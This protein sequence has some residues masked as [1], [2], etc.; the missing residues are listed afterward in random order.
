[1]V[2]LPSYPEYENYE[3]KK[4]LE[5]I[6]VR[7]F[8]LD[9]ISVDY[10][11]DMDI[12]R[13]GFVV[14]F[15]NNIDLLSITEILN[16]KFHLS[17]TGSELLYQLAENLCSLAIVSEMNQLDNI[18]DDH[19]KIKFALNALSINYFGTIIDND[20]NGFD[21]RINHQVLKFFEHLNSI[22]VETSN[23]LNAPTPQDF[24]NAFID[25][26]RIIKTE[27]EKLIPHL[28]GFEEKCLFSEF[29]ISKFLPETQRKYVTFRATSSQVLSSPRRNISEIS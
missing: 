14:K 12:H 3:I 15:E 13:N 17:E 24:K 26:E 19:R 7:I 9:I 20:G 2:I 10:F 5:I 11:K 28:I 1:M 29:N 8:P 18:F 22:C 23:P 21:I 4:A 16:P 27:F 25:N 6:G